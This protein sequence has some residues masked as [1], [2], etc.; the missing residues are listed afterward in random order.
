MERLRCAGSV[1]VRWVRA[2]RFVRG[3]GGRG[4]NARLFFVRCVR[5]WVT[6][7]INGET[8]TITAA[9]LGYKN[10]EESSTKAR[11][12]P[13]DCTSHI[14]RSKHRDSVVSENIGNIYMLVLVI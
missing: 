6:G 14:D 11:K 5:P 7:S 8:K 13:A 3:V 2:V 4:D 10:V 9:D 12:I 1:A